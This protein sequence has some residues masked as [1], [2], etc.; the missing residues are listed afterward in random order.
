MRSNLAPPRTAGTLPT[1]SPCPRLHA[2]SEFQETEPN[3][4]CMQA[5]VPAKNFPKPND[6]RINP[7][8]QPPPPVHSNFPIIRVG[9][10]RS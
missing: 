10:L 5:C 9:G 1:L 7:N 8:N 4:S 3:S 2:R 6:Y